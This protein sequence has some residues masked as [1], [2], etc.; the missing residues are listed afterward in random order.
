MYIRFSRNTGAPQKYG[1]NPDI[2]VFEKL[3]EMVMRL[4]LLLVEETLL[5]VLSQPLSSTFWTERIGSVAGLK[6]L[7]IMEREKSWEQIT[8]MEPKLEN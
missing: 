8:H 7:E 3:W 4:Q 1:V 2:A 6:T 5:K